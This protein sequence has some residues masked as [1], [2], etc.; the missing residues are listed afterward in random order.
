MALVGAALLYR[1][2][3]SPVLGA[4][5][6][7]RQAVEVGSVM[8]ERLE[9][10]IERRD[11]IRARLEQRFGP[12]VHRPLQTVDEARVAFPASAQEAIQRSGAS[13]TQ[14][15]V[16]G[17]RRVRDLPGVSMLSIRVRV[18]C[19]ASALPAMLKELNYTDFAVV[20]E[21]MQ[22]TMANPGQRDQWQAV[23]VLSTPALGGENRS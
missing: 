9:E 11:A 15:E 1:L 6:Q 8:L 21:S 5:V 16:Q 2:V 12:S 3:F 18:M 22:L 14:V 4:W 23:M 20:V 10:K 17:V 13:A 7:S 19:E